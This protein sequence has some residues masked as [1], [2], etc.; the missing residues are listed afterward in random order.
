MNMYSI[1][2][3]KAG[4]YH[5]PCFL[6]ND[7]VAKRMFRATLRLKESLLREFPEDFALC[8]IGEWDE[9]TGKVKQDEIK[10]LGFASEFIDK[11]DEEQEE[12]G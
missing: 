8:R 7:I 1:W 2:D 3:V 12:P 11:D 5:R 9:K 10:N 4:V 6:E